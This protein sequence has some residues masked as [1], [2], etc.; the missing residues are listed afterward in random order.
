ML[1]VTIWAVIAGWLA[2]RRGYSFLKYF[3]LS[4]IITPLISMI[5][6]LSLV[7]K[8]KIRKKA[9]SEGKTLKQ[10]IIESLC[11]ENKNKN[12]N[13]VFLTKL[14]DICDN[15]SS[16]PFSLRDY[17]KLVRKKGILPKEYIE[18]IFEHYFPN[19]IEDMWRREQFGTFKN[20]KL[21]DNNETV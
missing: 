11:K 15:L 7:N 8:N 6:V 21:P 2:I 10:C 13:N 20:P 17:L 19:Y 5:I 12:K 14:F 16:N 18:L 3:L 4:Y 9:A 1:G